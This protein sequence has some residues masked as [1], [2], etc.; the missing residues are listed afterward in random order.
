MIAVHTQETLRALSWDEVRKLHTSLGLKATADSRTRRDY[1][2]RILAVQP[3]KV[4]ESAPIAPQ[5]SGEEKKPDRGSGRVAPVPRIWEK[6]TSEVAI[7]DY[8]KMPYHPVWL[9]AD[10]EQM[11]DGCTRLVVRASSGHSEEW[12]LPAP[13]TQPTWSLDEIEE[14]IAKLKADILNPTTLLDRPIRTTAFDIETIVWKSPFEGEI[15]DREEKRRHFFIENDCIFLVIQTGSRSFCASERTHKNYHH[16]VIR[17]S[18][19][20]GKNFDPL[21]TI[22]ESCRF[23]RIH[24]SCDGW[25]W[26]WGDGQATGHK[27]P[28]R[29]MALKYLEIKNAELVG[30][31]VPPRKLR[32]V[33]VAGV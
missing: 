22:G 3:Q 17:Q 13:P 20:A 2:N 29:S 32:A 12:Y 6:A 19:E 30:D 33:S 4:E 18:V 24:Q 23:G 27:F 14:A 5:A 10:K 21:S 15:L 31:G 16:T 8:I 7:G 9:V 1:E 28:L 11:D 26:V 25:W